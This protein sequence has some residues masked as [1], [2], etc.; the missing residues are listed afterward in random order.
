MT[1]HDGLT[2]SQRYYIR[3]KNKVK[4]INDKNA[5]IQYAK[6][7]STMEDLKKYLQVLIAAYKESH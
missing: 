7:M 6:S 2:A 5:G 1:I 3:H 4:S